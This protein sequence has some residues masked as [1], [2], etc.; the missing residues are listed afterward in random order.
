MSGFVPDSRRAVGVDLG[1]TNVRAAL[2]DVG[3][4]AI[5]G[6]EQKQPVGSKDPDVVVELVAELVKAVDPDG[7]RVG[8]G[9]GV[10]DVELPPELAGGVETPVPSAG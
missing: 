5:C 7:V 6:A 4:G 3:S 2:V 8:V 1:G 10:A 9:V